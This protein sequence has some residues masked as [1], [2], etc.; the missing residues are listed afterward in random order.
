MKVVVESAIG[1]CVGIGGRVIG[2]NMHIAYLVY[3][4]RF[5]FSGIVF[6][7]GIIV[8]HQIHVRLIPFANGVDV[9]SHIIR[10]KMIHTIVSKIV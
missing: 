3:F 10:L 9:K 8:Y 7:I 5:G 4:E 6:L 1:D 2:V